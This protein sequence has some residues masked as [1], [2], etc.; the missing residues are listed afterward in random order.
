MPSE[1]TV[2]VAYSAPG[3]QIVLTG[4]VRDFTSTHEDFGDPEPDHGYGHYA[5]NVSQ[6]IGDDGAP[7]QVHGVTDFEILF[8]TLVPGVP[9]AAR[10]SV[11]GAEIT[12]GGDPVPVTIQCETDTQLFEPYGPYN[13][14]S[15]PGDVNDNAHPKHFIFS[16]TE[17][18]SE[19]TPISVTAR[20]WLPSFD[21]QDFGNDTVYPQSGTFAG[22]AMVATQITLPEDGTVTSLTAYV[23][24]DSNDNTDIRYAIYEDNGG[25]P[26]DLI[27][28]TSQGDQTEDW[29]WT[30]L[31]IADTWLA[32][33]DYWLAV[34]HDP[35]DQRVRFDDGT[36]GK[37]RRSTTAGV[38][39]FASSWGSSS[40]SWN[41]RS[42]SI[43]LSYTADAPTYSQHLTAKS[44]DNSPYVL[45]L[46]DGDSVPNIPGPT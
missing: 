31:G 30:S 1:M 6:I 46:K 34:S 17:I 41:D 14:P 35:Q 28:Q 40:N 38:D 20:S 5:G 26:G 2:S 19:E 12:S 22:G 39:G 44:G 8:G 43:Y 3:D 13:D 23:Y 32:A 33:G 4:M 45:V 29:G 37:T 18:Y 21:L 11:L 10:A 25:E 27:V 36:G 24:C 9:Y 7:L 16:L 15:G 42:V